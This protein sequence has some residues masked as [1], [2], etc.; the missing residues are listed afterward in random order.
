MVLLGAAAVVAG[1]WLILLGAGDRLTAGLFH[2][3][4]L[5]R[6]LRWARANPARGAAA[7]AAVEAVA[8]A[9]LCPGLAVLRGRRGALRPVPGRRA[10]WAGLAAGKG[11]RSLWAGRCCGRGWRRGSRPRPRGGALMDTAL[12][13]GGW[14]LVVLL[15]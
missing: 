5:A 6:A 14:R 4:A 8:V 11:R 7:F 3:E 9:A 12:A 10:G 15:R 1:R 13:K 2:G